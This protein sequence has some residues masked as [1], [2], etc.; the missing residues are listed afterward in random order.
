MQQ[1][2]PYQIITDDVVN[3]VISLFCAFEVY[4]V[5]LYLVTF[6]NIKK[7]FVCIQN[8]LI[9]AFSGQEFLFTSISLEDGRFFVS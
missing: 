7:I 4:L 8:V 2:I 5:I 6:F 3:D 9:L 1:G